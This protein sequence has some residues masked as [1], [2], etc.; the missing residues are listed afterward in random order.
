[1]SVDER[2]CPNKI[3]KVFRLRRLE[4][5]S[6]SD[7]LTWRTEGAKGEDVVDTF[8]ID[9]LAGPVIAERWGAGT[10]QA[11]LYDLAAGGSRVMNGRSPRFAVSEGGEVT[12]IGRVHTK[13]PPRPVTL[14]G[15]TSAEAPR[16]ES[17]EDPRRDP[18]QSTDDNLSLRTLLRRM[19]GEEAFIFWHAVEAEMAAHNRLRL[20]RTTQV[21]DQLRELELATVRRVVNAHEDVQKTRLELEAKHLERQYVAKEKDARTRDDLA[22]LSDDLKEAQEELRELRAELAQAKA[23]PTAMVPAG[24]DP[25]LVQAALA[26]VPTLLESEA[27]QGLIKMA[28]P[29]IA[30]MVEGVI[31]AQMNGANGA[32]PARGQTS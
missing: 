12:V 21:F 14:P 31:Q 19:N 18:P 11:E 25:R 28:G 6:F 7:P 8:P 22:D 26:I 20:D 23:T 29:R 16:Q 15:A 1:M 13:G 4:D 17:S 5:D 24:I 27:V 9:E 2:L 32:I 10:F 3:V 30:K